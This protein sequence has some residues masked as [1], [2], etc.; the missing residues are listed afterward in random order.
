MGHKSLE[1]TLR[2]SHLAPSTLVE[3]VD[4]LDEFSK[5]AKAEP[6]LRVVKGSA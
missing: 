2:Y 3:A 4:K 6:D 1:M 5:K